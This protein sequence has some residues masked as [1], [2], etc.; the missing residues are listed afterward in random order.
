VTERF[1]TADLSGLFAPSS[2][3]VVGASSREGRP[4]HFVLQALQMMGP[5][6]AIYPITPRYEEILGLA[7]FADLASAPRADLVIIASASDRIEAELEAAAASGARGAV[8]FGAPVPG[9]RRVA[10]LERVAGVAR[11]AR[12]PVLGPDSL[13]FVDF[14][15][16]VAATWSLPEPSPAGGIAVISQSGTVYWEAN[17]NDPRLRFSFTAHAGLEATL[18]MADLVR[19]ALDLPTT[20]VIGLYVETIRDAEGFVEALEHAADRAVPVVALYAG[21]TEQA[22]AQMTTHAGRLAG[23]RASLE[24]LFRHY[25]VVRAESPD[26]WWTTLALLGNPRPLADGG[27]AAVMDSGGGLAM[28]LDYAHEFGVPLAQLA[29]RT[30]QRLR[31][32]LGIENVT[33]GALDFWIGDADRHSNADSLLE[34]LAAD[35]GTAA[36]MAFTTYAETRRAGFAPRVAD[37]CRRAHGQTTKPVFAATYTSRQVTPSLMLDLADEGIPILDGMR[38]AVRSMSHAFDVRQ[39]QS[40]WTGGPSAPTGLDDDAV[41]AGRERL[42]R[43]A[44][45]LEADALEVLGGLGV[46]VVATQRA[47]S[48]DEAAAAATAVGYPVVVKSDEGITH[49]AQRGGVRLGLADDAAVRRAY[50]EMSGWLGP[51][52]VVAPMVRGL[53]VAVGVVA[54]EFGPLLMLSA[55]GTM[56]ELLDDRCYLL[57]PATPEEVARALGDLAVGRLAKSSLRP[58]AFEGF[59][60]LASRVSEIAAVYRGVVRELDINPVMVSDEG[61]LAIDALIGTY[62]REEAS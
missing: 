30:I 35:P 1:A 38:T 5:T 37:A 24:G 3:A 34:V 21:L 25:G 49:K 40:R 43:S 33:T 52:V 42:E 59:C 26:D 62:A 14:A 6:G 50:D 39:F 2:V 46:P 17:T 45:L 7:C 11:S 20:R 28:F 48:A 8:V 51:R 56:I 23:G 60:D 22:R 54:G 12:L 58:A 19:Y 9:E 55:G 4:G 31:D 57:A 41:A 32:V 53:E 61:C 13:G 47:S 15:H 16:R 10:W 36:V 29:P 18:S 27:L 44:E